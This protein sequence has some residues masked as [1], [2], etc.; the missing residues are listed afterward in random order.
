MVVKMNGKELMDKIKE[1]NFVKKNKTELR[2]TGLVALSF[3]TLISFTGLLIFGVKYK[4][5]SVEMA[6]LIYMYSS[7]LWAFSVVLMIML[8]ATIHVFKV[9]PLFKIHY[10][11]VD[12]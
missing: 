4:I 12:K 5:I 2:L 9:A 6:E 8:I 3:P 7:T 11:S 10:Y 1:S